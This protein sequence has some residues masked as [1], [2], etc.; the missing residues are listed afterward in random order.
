[1]PGSC[2]V[3]LDTQASTVRTR[4]ARRRRHAG[5]TSTSPGDDFAAV[6]IMYLPNLVQLGPP[7]AAPLAVERPRF[8]GDVGLLHGDCPLARRCRMPSANT[9]MCKNLP[10]ADSSVHAN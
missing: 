3:P 9:A 7:M 8:A 4:H 5:K 10:S 6:K 1:M 2:G